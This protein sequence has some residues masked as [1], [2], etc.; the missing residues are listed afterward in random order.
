MIQFCSC[1]KSSSIHTETDDFMQW[2]V[3]NDCCKVIEDSMQYLNHYDGE[4]HV[5]EY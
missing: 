4:D 1:K 5:F 2:D 3:C